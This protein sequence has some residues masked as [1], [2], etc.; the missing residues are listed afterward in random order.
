MTKIK[1]DLSKLVTA[2]DVAENINRSLRD[3]INNERQRRILAGTTV[4]GIR[5][6]GSDN[7]TRNLMGLALGAQL[8]LAGGDNETIT[9][10]RDGDNVDHEL[11]PEEILALWQK[12]AAFVSMLYQKSWEIKALSPIPSDFTNDS[13]WSE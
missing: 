3:G 8:R 9:V 2:E 4:D 10:F 6:T 1:L 12:S 11:T 7:D 5:V 13:Y